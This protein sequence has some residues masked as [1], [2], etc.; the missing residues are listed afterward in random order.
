MDRSSKLLMIGGGALAV[1][2][3]GVLSFLLARQ[4]NT[5]VLPTALVGAAS[6]QPA[7]A[8]VLVATRPIAAGTQIKWSDVPGLFKQV[9]EPKS[10]VPTQAVFADVGQLV[11]LLQVTPR[12]T[13]VSLAPGEQLGASMLTGISLAGQGGPVASA[14]PRGFDG[15][16]VTIKS[17]NNAANN[18]IAVNDR[19]D[20]IYSLPKTG[21]ASDPQHTAMFIQGAQ[22]VQ[23]YPISNSYTLALLP[24]DAVRLAHVEEAGW[25]LHL[26]VRS[27]FDDSRWRTGGTTTTSDFK[28]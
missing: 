15:E 8:P 17:V 24:Q 18:A 12:R 6:T 26:V 5:A 3:A 20:V 2:V 14:L 19:V 27:V 10:A 28:R 13:V 7:V 23:T 11:T 16:A 22:V 9:Y 1:L 4:P 25:S 21:G